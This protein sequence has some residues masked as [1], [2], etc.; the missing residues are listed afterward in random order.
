MFDEGAKVNSLVNL[1]L[2]LIDHESCLELDLRGI[3]LEQ[4]VSMSF[5]YHLLNKG[6]SSFEIIVF[7]KSLDE[8]SE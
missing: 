5:S 4:E 3:I 7:V 1:G 8:L 6:L 2:N